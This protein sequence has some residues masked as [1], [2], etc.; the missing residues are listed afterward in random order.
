MESFNLNINPRQT[1]GS[2][3]CRRTRKDNQIPC[4][5]YGRKFDSLNAY[6]VT[7]EFKRLAQKSRTSQ[8]FKFE[9]ENSDL[10]AKTAIVKDLQIHPI[11]RDV[12]HVDFQILQP[13]DLVKVI[14]PVEVTGEADGVKNQGG[15]LAV[16][17][18]EIT[19]S[20]SVENI[21]YVVTIDVSELKLGERIW[22]ENIKLPEGVKL[23]SNSKE[24]VASVVSSRVSKL[25]DSEASATEAGSAVEAGDAPATPEK[26][27]EK[28]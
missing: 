4:V 2:S 14:V 12:L 23:V 28:K 18:R 16:S 19:C 1:T 20:C 25:L 13:G 9:S 7:N 24:T 22:A 5:V 8:T 27:E 26:A 11:T 17:C 21:P 3:A 15:V 10:N 6:V